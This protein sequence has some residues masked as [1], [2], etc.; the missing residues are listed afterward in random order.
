MCFNRACPGRPYPLDYLR[1]ASWSA[2]T[3]RDRYWMYILRFTEVDIR[4]RRHWKLVWRMDL[5]FGGGGVEPNVSMDPF[6]VTSD[7]RRP[8]IYGG[9]YL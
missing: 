8:R 1:I 9:C 2:W 4:Q 7:Y 6:I 3:V 5:L